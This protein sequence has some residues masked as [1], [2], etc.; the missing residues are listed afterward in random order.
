MPLDGIEGTD[1]RRWQQQLLDNGLA[2]STVGT[3]HK[4]LQ[5]MLD[6]AVVDRYLPANPVHL[7]ARRRRSRRQRG[8]RTEQLWAKPEEALRVAENASILSGPWAATLIITAAWTGMRWG[9]VVG[10]HRR[11]LRGDVYV[12]DD[13]EVE[14]HEEDDGTLWLGPPKGYE[15]REV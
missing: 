4:I 7:P 3:I 6:D 11:F 1:E 10:M 12:I 14:L 5:M 8:P 13:H 15:G 2:H 9:E